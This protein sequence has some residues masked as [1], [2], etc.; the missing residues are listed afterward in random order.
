MKALVIYDSQFGNTEQIARTVGEALGAP[1]VAVEDAQPDALAGLDLLI[2]GSPTQGGRPTR[3]VQDFL[4]QVPRDALRGV[5]VAAFDTRIDARKHGPFLRLL[6][7]LIGYAAGR[8]AASLQ[9]HGGELV[10]GPE[11]FIVTGKEGPLKAGE[12]QRASSWASLLAG[13]LT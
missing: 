11:G 1:S 5:R 13:A 12:E 4:K 3:K 9:S 2:V 10:G 8:L 6:T 7:S